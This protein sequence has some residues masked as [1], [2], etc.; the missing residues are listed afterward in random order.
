[1]TI[2][3]GSTAITDP[4]DPT[5]QAAVDSSGALKVSATF[6]ASSVAINDGTNTSNKLAVDSDGKI[7]ISSMPS[8]TATNPS[9]GVD[10]NAI[11]T[12][13]T[14]IG[15]SDGTNLQQ[16]LVESASHPN[17][18]TG[19]YN[20][21]NEMAVDASG[22]ASVKLGAA[23]PTGTNSI[24][25]VTSNAGVNLNTSALAL[26][27]GGNLASIKSDADSIVTNTANIPA[28]GQATMAN[29]T[30]V[31]IASNQSTVNIS[32]Q[33]AGSASGTLQNAQNG[34]A[35]GSTL[36]VLGMSACSW[37][38]NMS[39]FTGTVN[40]EASSD[41]T[42]FT[43]IKALQIGTDTVVTT[44]A[45]STT[46]SITTFESSVGSLQLIRARTSGVSAGSVTVT[47]VAT[48]VPFSPR[49]VNA[50]LLAGS[51]V[52][53]STT[54][55]ATSGTALVADQSNTELRTSV[56]GKNSAA[57]DTP[58]ATDSS[59]RVLT[60]NYI[61]GSAVSTSNP[62]PSADQIR[63][64]IINGQGFSC[65]T[66]KQTAGSAISTGFGIF[67]PN[68]SGKTLIVYSIKLLVGNTS[69]NPI[70]YV[71]TDPAF[72]SSMTIVNRKAGS[73]TASVASVSFSNTTQTPGTA[74]DMISGASNT[75]LQLLQNGDVLYIPPSNGVNVYPNLSGA[76]SW[77][78]SAQWCE[79]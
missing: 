7:G 27:S 23:I 32:Q 69:F 41:G 65:Q 14:L 49:T 79:V 55:Q 73:G 45:G 37:V 36:N 1:M 61:S 43:A 46:T 39:G 52:I 40:F 64:W 9:V 58:I 76:N 38:V 29:S 78:V 50:N 11:P 35:N 30:P 25:Q 18:R 42:N 62:Y 60:A 12:S 75:N 28:K 4:T 21:A 24:G 8:V 44:T 13:S 66:G 15:G 10:G 70:T 59:G 33:A 47:A 54:I 2:P 67:N 6:S 77:S 48:P 31:V 34:N 71:T 74:N 56:Y 63:L 19:V 22:N 5:H 3:T 20:G 26:E 16:A 68:A 17:L 57:G 72:G 53:G 51:A